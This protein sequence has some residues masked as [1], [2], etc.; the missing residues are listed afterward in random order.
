MA[1]THEEKM[2]AREIMKRIAQEEQ[3]QIDEMIKRESMEEHFTI[4]MIYIPAEWYNNDRNMGAIIF[5]HLVKR[6]RQRISID[7]CGIMYDTA[8]AFMFGQPLVGKNW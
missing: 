7:R 3:K 4:G 2:K 5:N 6:N 1:L 8:H